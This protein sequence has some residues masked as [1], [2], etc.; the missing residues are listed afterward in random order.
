MRFIAALL[1]ETLHNAAD[2]LT[3]VPLG[4]VFVV[5]RPAD[6]NRHTALASYR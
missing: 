5:G 3:A 1:G 6:P 4:I 2:A